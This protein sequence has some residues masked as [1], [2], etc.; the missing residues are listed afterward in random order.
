MKSALSQL[1]HSSM[2]LSASSLNT[3][4]LIYSKSKHQIKQKLYNLTNEFI[5]F[6]CF[7]FFVVLIFELVRL[8]FLVSNSID[9]TP[10]QWHQIFVVHSNF[11][12]LNTFWTR[13]FVQDIDMFINQRLIL[14]KLYR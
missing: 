8:Q 10:I 6:N 2:H 9:L 7:S 5:F 11:S 13:I 4:G 3:I 1:S 14:I 12:I